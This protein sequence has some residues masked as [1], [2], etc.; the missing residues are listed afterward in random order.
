[1]S[2]DESLALAGRR[3][4]L[5]GGFVVTRLLPDVRR[6]AVGPFVFVDHMGPHAFPPGEGIDVRP[7]PHIG[8]ATLTW[9]VEGALLHRDSVGSVQ[10][11]RPGD[12]NWMSAG[13]G[14]VHS[15][16]TPDDRRA[17]GQ[18]VE[19]LQCWVALPDASA[20]D[21][22]FFQHVAGEG[23]PAWTED[24][25]QVVLVAGSW[26]G[27]RSPVRTASPVL[28]A[29]LHFAAGGACTLRDVPSECAVFAFDEGLEMDGRRLAPR[30]LHVVA[31]GSAA[32]LVAGAA[33][34]AVILGGE[35]VGPR[36]MWWNFVASDRARIE[37]AKADWA[38]GRFDPVPGEVDSIP[39]PE[40]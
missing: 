20:E 29:Q 12:V 9:L 36:H 22:P 5:G 7:H 25:V 14:I 10:V 19:G 40:R 37:Q 6:R 18:R 27:R 11:V 17:G 24:G 15:E 30:A 32:R 13:R 26:S 8:L 34:R 2:S 38:A 4:D 33:V 28:F 21:A 1:M 39:L 35:C 16:R 31:S 23:L 3:H